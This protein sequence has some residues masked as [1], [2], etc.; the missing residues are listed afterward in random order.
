MFTTF[1]KML[2]TG[3]FTLGILSGVVTLLRSQSYQQV[4][5]QFDH[6]LLKATPWSIRTL[7]EPS[8]TNIQ[9][10]FLENPDVIMKIRA[11]SAKDQ[12][13][14]VYNAPR[15]ELH[16]TGTG[17]IALKTKEELFQLQYKKSKLPL[18]TLSDV[19]AANPNKRFWIDIDQPASTISKEL[20]G[21]FQIVKNSDLI[22]VSSHFQD[23]T[24]N[25]RRLMPNFLAGCSVSETASFQLFAN[26]WMESLPRL[27][28]DFYEVK[29][30][31]P[32]L[33]H[34]I[35]RRKKVVI[36]PNDSKLP[37]LK[38][39]ANVGWLIPNPLN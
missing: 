31:H 2:L 29:N 33:V 37:I 35:L 1:T 15:L 26:I 17:F 11:R 10:T 28:C 30:D 27:A 13:W 20:G 22:V 9:K 16:T 21:I 4:Y 3:L 6:P 12:T 38:D 32:R 24:T 25:M 19:L 7:D 36:L 39:T 23:T 14:M 8:L 5:P 34:E 18:A